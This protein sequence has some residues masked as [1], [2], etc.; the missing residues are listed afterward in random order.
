[1][2]KISNDTLIHDSGKSGVEEIEASRVVPIAATEFNRKLRLI[3]DMV[4]LVQDKKKMK[5]KFSGIT[6]KSHSDTLVRA[7]LYSREGGVLSIELRKYQG[8]FFS[9]INGSPTKV[10]SGQN[11]INDLGSE[12]ETKIESLMT[13]RGLTRF[14]AVSILGFLLLHSHVKEVLNGQ[15]YFNAEELKKIVTGKVSVHSVGFA[16]YEKFGA[17]KNTKATALHWLAALSSSTVQ[18]KSDDNVPVNIQL[19]SLLDSTLTAT[20]RG[21]TTKNGYDGM[22]VSV[23]IRKTMNDGSILCE[24]TI[25]DKE[26]EVLDKQDKPTGRGN[27]IALTGL[28]SEDRRSLDVHVRVDNIFFKGYLIDWIRQYAGHFSLEVDLTQAYIHDLSP[29]FDSPT[30]IKF[31]VAHMR[32]ELGLRSLLM[33][34][35]T[36]E[37]DWLMGDQSPLDKDLI[38][39]L[40]EWRNSPT[41]NITTSKRG[42]VIQ[43]S[44]TEIFS[45]EEKLLLSSKYYLR[46]SSC[47]LFYSALNEARGLF[48]LDSRNRQSLIEFQRNPLSLDF[49]QTSSYT[50]LLE[51]QVKAVSLMTRFLRK[52]VALPHMVVSKKATVKMLEGPARREE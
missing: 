40:E 22:N 37:L 42:L 48:S 31:L 24:Q 13:S 19:I 6:L 17:D 4:R 5:G 41:P 44:T 18:M 36:R 3:L 32:N 27:M 47:Y 11:L 7:D 10:L 28:N 21:V 51:S 8:K 29:L 15:K 34:P 50:T 25:Y 52:S 1:M 33:A 43:P 26:T 14:E 39:K 30:N 23:T 2:K 12:M 45:P 20:L 49:K 46:V 35:T 16:S 9:G 38:R